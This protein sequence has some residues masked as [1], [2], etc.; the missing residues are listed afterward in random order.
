ME[1][2]LEN[3]A[4]ENK[5]LEEDLD[6]EKTQEVHEDEKASEDIGLTEK[7]A[8]S[9]EVEASEAAKEVSASD[10]IKQQAL[11]SEYIEKMNSLL[12]KEDIT[13]EDIQTVEYVKSELLSQLVGVA[14]FSSTLGMD[15]SKMKGA[16]ALSTHLTNVYVKAALLREKMERKRLAQLEKMD[17]ADA[18][19]SPNQRGA[20]NSS[21]P[22]VVTDMMLMPNDHHK[23]KVGLVNASP[24]VKQALM[25]SEL[26]NSPKERLTAMMPD[27]IQEFMGKTTP[28]EQKGFSNWAEK[29][30]TGLT[31]MSSKGAM[32]QALQ[33]TSVGKTLARM[34]A[35]N[36][37]AG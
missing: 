30:V 27:L 34:S 4:L 3:E 25:I 29:L 12:N 22:M 9:Q 32:M 33:G 26:I 6:L 37:V 10:L 11:Q 14:V 24:K 31:G 35:L 7:E 36:E 19:F 16:D 1:K 23:L 21:I 17:V 13:L 18:F 28:E 8:S 15:D 5:N 2:E 20:N